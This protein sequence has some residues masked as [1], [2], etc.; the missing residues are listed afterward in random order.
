[1]FSSDRESFE[2]IRQRALQEIQ[3]IG[4]G[5]VAW[6]VVGEF[7]E[8]VRASESWKKEGANSF[9]EWVRS[10][11]PFSVATLWRYHAAARYLKQLSEKL[12]KGKKPQESLESLPGTVS[13][14]N[15]ELLAKLA[16]VAPSSVLEPLTEGVLNGSIRRNELR[17]TWQAFRPA[18]AGRTARGRGSAIPQ[19]D[20]SNPLQYDN[21]LKGMVLNAL[22][23]SGPS[24]TGCAK[25]ALYRL[26]FQVSPD[27]DPGLSVLPGRFDAVA[28]LRRKP[29]APLELHE[30]ECVG[31]VQDA[32]LWR[33][34]SFANQYTDYVW[35]A[36]DPK[37]SSLRGMPKSVGCLMVKGSRIVVGR[38]AAR[39]KNPA[40]RAALLAALVSRGLGG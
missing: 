34:V 5:P 21:L 7:L 23:R 27:P 25:P 22:D 26:F 15:I 3:N 33:I 2:K 35:V 19:V 18:L 31:D 38:P 12:A 9:T 29:E 4:L 30:V 1:M 17:R 40:S 16:R 14:E 36:S 11:A 39:T 37:A 10:L 28:V 20:Q 32:A 8:R 13:P 6:V 24:W